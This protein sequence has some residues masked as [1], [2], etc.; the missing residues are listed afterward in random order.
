M[1]VSIWG[2]EEDDEMRFHM[3][4]GISSFPWKKSKDLASLGPYSHLASIGQNQ[5]V[6]AFSKQ[7]KYRGWR[8]GGGRRED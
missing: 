8:V 4:P 2:L 1:N 7:A 3:K 6:A 5:T